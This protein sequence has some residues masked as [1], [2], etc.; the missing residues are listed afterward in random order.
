MLPQPWRFLQTRSSVAVGL[1][2]P[3]EVPPG[4]VLR[5]ERSG[6]SLKG[7]RP[8]ALRQIPAGRIILFRQE[9][10]GEEEVAKRG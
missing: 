8:S 1:E 10:L 4:T 6:S 3:E 2:L 5:C 7:L 9:G